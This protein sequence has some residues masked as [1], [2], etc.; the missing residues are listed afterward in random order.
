MLPTTGILAEHSHLAWQGHD[1]TKTGLLPCV[2]LSLLSSHDVHDEACLL[3]Y[4]L[5]MG[6]ERGDEVANLPRP[7]NISRTTGYHR[8][9]S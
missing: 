4:Q 7:S 2:R 6:G 5:A 8:T 3:P 1:R 9:P